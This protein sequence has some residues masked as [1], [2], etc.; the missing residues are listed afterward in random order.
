MCKTEKITLQKYL[1]SPLNSFIYSL[2]VKNEK[3]HGKKW[4]LSVSLSFE[5]FD[6]V[7]DR[8]LRRI[9]TNEWAFS[10][11]EK[12]LITKADRIFLIDKQIPKVLFNIVSFFFHTKL[13]FQVHF[14][15][16]IR[17]IWRR[18]FFIL[19]GFWN[20]CLHIIR[21]LI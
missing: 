4:S 2:F 8:V 18:F 12:I 7:G 3:N 17:E 9:K 19:V 15:E 21:L 14:S 11:R 5:L 6:P 13:S 16:K 20:N 1:W 10:D